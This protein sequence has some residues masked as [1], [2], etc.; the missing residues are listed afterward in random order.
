MSTIRL[1]VAL[2]ALGSVPAASGF[3]ACDK[4]AAEAKT[5][6]AEEAR[7]ASARADLSR[8]AIGLC[9]TYAPAHNALGTALE[10]TGDKAGAAAE[11]ERAA[12]LDPAW[13]LPVMGLGDL[14]KA[15]G[16]AKAA[17]AHYVKAVALAKNAKEREVADQALAEVRKGG[18]YAFKSSESIA[19]TLK[20]SEDAKP[21]GTRTLGMAEPVGQDFYESA[22]GLAMNLSIIFRVNS[23]DLTREGTKQL[24]EVGK[25]LATA[26]EKVHFRIE[27]SSSSEGSKDVNMALSTSRA[28]GVR[29]YLV[30]R[31]KIAVGRLE[32]IGRGSEVPVIENGKENREKS[33]RVTMIRLYDP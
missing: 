17:E 9:D 4:P 21:S 10:E 27:G 22:S 3:P 23:A 24:D 8:Q 12:E 33:R 11:Y 13:Y 2:A 15:S 18:G 25:A 6:Q 19:R 16:D 1:V 29:D 28:L 26:P 14:A 7:N 31:Y 20:L 30:K 32:A 5:K